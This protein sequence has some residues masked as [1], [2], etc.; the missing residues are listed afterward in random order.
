[1][2]LSMR[3]AQSVLAELVRRGIPEGQIAV[4]AKGERD[5]LVPT[6]DGVREPQNRRV[7]IVFR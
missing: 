1:M 6:P 3:R 5:P 7:E 4:F 2:G